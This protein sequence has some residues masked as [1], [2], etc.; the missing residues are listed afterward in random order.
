[1][2]KILGL[3]VAVWVCTSSAWADEAADRKQE[4]AKLKTQTQK[5]QAELKKYR[6]QEKKISKEITALQNQKAQA[7]RMKNKVLLNKI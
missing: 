1:M 4:L 5:K 7:E 3:L 6:E 2:A